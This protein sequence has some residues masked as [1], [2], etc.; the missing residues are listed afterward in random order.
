MPTGQLLVTALQEVSGPPLSSRVTVVADST[1]TLGNRAQRGEQRRQHVYLPQRQILAVSQAP[2][3]P[4]L[5]EPQVASLVDEVAARRR[6][7]SRVVASRWPGYQ[8]VGLPPV[9]PLIE[10]RI[11]DQA[12]FPAERRA[13][14]RGAVISLRPQGLSYPITGGHIVSTSET[15]ETAPR[16]YRRGG[17][18]GIRWAGYAWANL[19]PVPRLVEPLVQTLVPENAPRRHPGSIISPRSAAYA[20]SAGPPPV[21]PRLIQ[22]LVVQA[23]Q[24]RQLRHGDVLAP[25]PVFAPIMLPPRPVMVGQAGARR[26]E[27]PR[28]RGAVCQP[29][30]RTQPVSPPRPVLV[31][32]APPRHRRKTSIVAPRVRVAASTGASNVFK[33]L[34]AYPSGTPYKGAPLVGDTGQPRA[35]Y[36]GKTSVGDSAQPPGGGSGTV[37]L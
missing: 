12:P 4:R 30:T 15:D 27:A 36:A 32:S 26:V 13:H 35:G 16:R 25:R 2:A 9:L 22:P 33:A 3:A 34:Q 29:R 11:V 1:A 20:A 10:P 31:R 21:T 37:K 24:A 14:T 23:R 8:W 7:Q 6:I 28:L 19:P 5:I 18:Y 17:V